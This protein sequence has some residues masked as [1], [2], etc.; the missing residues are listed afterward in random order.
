[1]VA[2]GHQA[3]IRGSSAVSAIGGT[4]L[5]FGISGVATGNATLLKS[6]LSDSTWTIWILFRQL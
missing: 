2:W 5:V 4:G 3:H 1:M 6:D